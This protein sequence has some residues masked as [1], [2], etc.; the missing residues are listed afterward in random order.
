MLV[1]FVGLELDELRGADN[2][3]FAELP[4]NQKIGVTRDDTRR[5][6]GNGGAQYRIIV[7]IPTD[8]R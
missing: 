4:K 7:R 8:G 5:L 1:P 2:A 3:D 6:A